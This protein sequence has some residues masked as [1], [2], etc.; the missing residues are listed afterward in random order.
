LDA[1]PA[2]TRAAGED[3]VMKLRLS[4]GTFLAAMIFACVGWLVLYSRGTTAREAN[5][6][7]AQQVERGFFSGVVLMSRDGNVLFE[8]A[9]GMANAEEKIPNTLQTRFRIASI[10][11]T[12]TAVIVMQ[13]EAEHRLALSE[14]ICMYIDECPPRWADIKLHHLLSHT[15]G[16]YNY[17]RPKPGEQ[18]IEQMLTS[19]NHTKA[20]VFARF[21]HEPLAF[22][23]GEKFDYSNSN[24]WLLTQVIEKVTGHSYEDALRVRILEPADMRDTGLTHDWPA[25]PQAAVGYWMTRQGKFERA[26]VE[27][28]SWSSGDGGIY[29]TVLDL[30]KFSD[31]LENGRLIRLATLQRMRTP[32]Q[33]VYGYGWQTPPVSKFTLNRKRVSHTGAL[34]GFL[35]DFE[36][37]EDEKVT[38]IALSNDQRSNPSQVAQALASVLFD[39]PFTPVF[40]RESVELPRTVLQRYAGDYEIAGEVFTVFLRDGRLYARGTDGTSPETELLAASEGLLFIK[41]SP[42]EI[43][44]VETANGEVKGLALTQEDGSRLAKKVR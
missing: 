43:T 6:M 17:T 7:M 24:Y 9:Y 30:E 14:S 1:L 22:V 39:M 15:S 33:P 13:L 23:P 11:K 38:V 12:F 29:S 27:D 18:Q 26:P 32:V 4:G 40:E 25:T 28:G 8:H 36:R 5:K 20:D 3:G 37:F 31:A 16:I 44:V 41:Q 2:G 10:S 35:S 34:P 42:V 19:T 21:I